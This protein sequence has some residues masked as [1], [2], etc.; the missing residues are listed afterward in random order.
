[1]QAVSQNGLYVVIRMNQRIVVGRDEE[2]LP[3]YPPSLLQRLRVEGMAIADG[4][5]LG[6]IRCY[7]QSR[8]AMTVSAWRVKDQLDLNQRKSRLR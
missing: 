2:I 5:A 6:K 8:A 4:K 1:M 3:P 7:A